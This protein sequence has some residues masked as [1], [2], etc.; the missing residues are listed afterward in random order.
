MAGKGECKERSPYAR[1]KWAKQ[2][3]KHTN[4]KTELRLHR[5]RETLFLTSTRRCG[6]L[7]HFSEGNC[8]RRWLYWNK[9]FAPFSIHFSF[10]SITTLL[11][12]KCPDLKAN[13]PQL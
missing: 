12:T 11:P 3:T 1:W 10:L 8:G 2:K 7:E 6:W 5:T 4:R 13:V 9:V